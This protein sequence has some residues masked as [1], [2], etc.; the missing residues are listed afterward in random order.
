MAEMPSEE[1]A[2]L[3]VMSDVLSLREAVQKLEMTVSKLQDDNQIMRSE[4]NFIKRSLNL[5]TGQVSGTST[6]RLVNQQRA[7]LP[8]ANVTPWRSVNTTGA[9]SPMSS[10]HLGQQL[11]TGSMSPDPAK[12][13]PIGPQKVRMS[14]GSYTPPAAEEEED[15][16]QSNGPRGQGSVEGDQGL[17]A[18]ELKVKLLV[19]R[20]RV[21]LVLSDQ[22]R[23]ELS[24]IARQSCCHIKFDDTPWDAGKYFVLHF[25]KVHVT[26]LLPEAVTQAVRLIYNTDERFQGL[27]LLV[28][29]NALGDHDWLSTLMDRSKTEISVA[30]SLTTNVSVEQMVEQETEIAVSGTLVG[31]G[32]VIQEVLLRQSNE[33]P[34]ATGEEDEDNI[35]DP[36]AYENLGHVSPEMTEVQF[37]ADLRAVRAKMTLHGLTEESFARIDPDPLKTITDTLLR[38]GSFWRASMLRVLCSMPFYMVSLVLI[39]FNIVLMWIEVDLE[40]GDPLKSASAS[41]QY[42]LTCVFLVEALLHLAVVPKIWRYRD[43]MMDVCVCIIAFC[44]E[45]VLVLAQIESSATL[46]LFMMRGVRFYRFFR[47]IHSLPSARTVRVILAGFK[48]AMLNLFWVSGFLFVTIYCGAILFRSLL[49]TS[50][51]EVT[52]AYFS[53]VSM[54]MLTLLETFLGGFDYSQYITRPLLMN[55]ETVWVGILW[56][57]YQVTMQLVVVNLVAGLFIEQLS[58]AAKK[59]DEFAEKEGLLRDRVTYRQ[60]VREFDRVDFRK[61]RSITLPELQYAFKNNVTLQRLLGIPADDT[62]EMEAFFHSNDL[63]GSGSLSFM[64]FAYGILTRRCGSRDLKTIIFDQVSKGIIR[65]NRATKQT[66]RDTTSVVLASASEAREMVHFLTSQRQIH[67]SKMQVLQKQ[68][69]GLNGKMDQVFSIVG[70][71]AGGG[72]DS[73]LNLEG[74]RQSRDLLTLLGSVRRSLEDV[75]AITA[76]SMDR[77]KA[78]AQGEVKRCVERVQIEGNKTADHA[79]VA[80][81]AAALFANT[82]NLYARPEA[83]AIGSNSRNADGNQTSRAPVGE[84]GFAR[85]IGEGIAEIENVAGE[86][87]HGLG[88]VVSTLT[89][90]AESSATASAAT[91]T[92]APATPA[93]PGGAPPKSVSSKG[94]LPAFGATSASGAQD[95]NRFLSMFRHKQA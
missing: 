75:T 7:S 64:D 65:Q 26:S 69:E 23:Q 43:L 18:N 17:G 66:L 61:E 52:T 42:A 38:D 19:P 29:N 35:Y 60:C 94:P 8:G 4:F 53:S 76:S 58:K 37:Q 45:T 1:R 16:T 73:N 36:K 82:A 44:L 54:C 9:M 77:L 56:L 24:K 2:K 63:T 86:F 81:R 91:S 41:C 47:L 48:G 5:K 49:R 14:V 28:P 78:E 31:L 70:A 34:N 93:Q 46:L 39:V 15:E 30:T 25:V 67:A 79:A 84:L 87:A 59:S 10:E 11:G 32:I 85:V 50:K 22:N 51:V 62:L 40:D 13:E 92:A 95:G 71:A 88:G 6:P 68:L 27:K 3:Q 74:I 90:A 83:S 20:R 80:A 89:G 33:N 12:E 72:S 55:K 21:R 57:A